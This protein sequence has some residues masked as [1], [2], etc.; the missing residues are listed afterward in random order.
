MFRFNFDLLKIKKKIV[1]FIIKR[2]IGKY[3]INTIDLESI[4]LNDNG[5]AIKELEIDPSLFEMF[6]NIVKLDTNIITDLEVFIPWSSI[7]SQSSKLTINKITLIFDWN[8]KEKI[9]ITE[10]TQTILQKTFDIKAMETYIEQSICEDKDFLLNSKSTENL[11]TQDA[12]DKSISECDGIHSLTTIIKSFVDNIQVFFDLIDIKVNF[13]DDICLN[14]QLYGVSIIQTPINDDTIE[15]S[16]MTYDIEKTIKIDEITLLI[17]DRTLLSLMSPR[18][19][20]WSKMSDDNQISGQNFDEYGVNVSVDF[21]YIY[22][23]QSIVENII[24]IINT[25]TPCF[26]S[27]GGNNMIKDHSISMNVTINKWK[28]V[29]ELDEENQIYSVSNDIYFKYDDRPI[30]GNN[31]TS[32]GNEMPST[33]LKSKDINCFPLEGSMTPKGESIM[34]S[35]KS[36]VSHQLVTYNLGV[37]SWE[38]Y[39]K[40]SSDNYD[41]IRSLNKE[42]YFL[43]LAFDGGLFDKIKIKLAPILFTLDLTFITKYLSIIQLLSSIGTTKKQVKSNSI[44]KKKNIVNLFCDLVHIIIKIPISDRV[45]QQTN[46]YDN[47]YYEESLFIDIHSLLGEFNNKNITLTCQKLLGNLLAHDNIINFLSIKVP[48]KEKPI[49]LQIM[50]NNL[51]DQDRVDES[52]DWFDN[53]RMVIGHQEVEINRNIKNVDLL[54]RDVMR[55]SKQ[56]LKL[57]LRHCNLYLDHKHFQV[58][59]N[60]LSEF[61]AW[62]SPFPTVESFYLLI[63]CSLESLSVN[64]T[65]HNFRYTILADMINILNTVNFY[66]RHK[67]T[68][69][70]IRD[71]YLY[72]NNTKKIILKKIDDTEPHFLK[73]GIDQLQP[74]SLTK[75]IIISMEFS[76]IKMLTR[77][78]QFSRLEKDHSFWLF[79]VINFFKKEY[80]IEPVIDTRTKL[81]INAKRLLTEYR[82]W[83]IP[84]KIVFDINNII[85]LNTYMGHNCLYSVSADYFD[86]G[87]STKDKMFEI[88]KNKDI[89]VIWMD[90]QIEMVNGECLFE[91]CADT[92]RII[93][94]IVQEFKKRNEKLELIEEDDEEELENEIGTCGTQHFKDIEAMVND[95]IRP[96]SIDDENMNKSI[97]AFSIYKLRNKSISAD[98]DKLNSILHSPLLDSENTTIIA[99]DINIEIRL[100]N[101]FEVDN[102]KDYNCYMMIIFDKINAIWFSTEDATYKKLFLTI[103][104]LESKLIYNKTKVILNPDIAYTF[105]SWALVEDSD[106]ALLNN[107]YHLNAMPKQ[108]ACQFL[109]WSNHISLVLLFDDE[110]QEDR[111]IIDT[112]PIILN[113]NQKTIDFIANYINYDGKLNKYYQLETDYVEVEDFNKFNKKS[114]S[115][116]HSVVIDI[117]SIKIIINYKSSVFDL[118]WNNSATI[119]NFVNLDGTK[120]VLKPF[121]YMGFMDTDMIIYEMSEYYINQ[122]KMNNSLNIIKSLSP[123]RTVV[124]IGSGIVNLVVI[125]TKVIGSSKWKYGLQKGVDKF[126]SSTLSEF[127]N[128]AYKIMNTADKL[129]YGTET[130]TLTLPQDEYNADGIANAISK[131]TKDTIKGGKKTM[132]DLK[133]NLSG[134]NKKEEDK[135]K[136]KELEESYEY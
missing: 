69:F 77:H 72:N 52:T 104:H 1:L 48:K 17:N 37:K 7:L 41:L 59:D 110:A 35:M 42:D 108:K 135:N 130:L 84:S 89:N 4:Q 111:F 107:I 91:L 109:D 14:L 88:V 76:N 103:R 127:A 129:F 63:N 49:V 121:R 68:Y 62:E 86:I 51:F 119:L 83:N 70:Q 32:I 92:I 50:N 53:D 98:Y 126:K 125:P 39:E 114:V 106:M 96:I 26:V 105:K 87:L 8:F 115:K 124:R 93:N 6:D 102:S 118:S 54:N 117:N 67:Y 36:T 21:I 22:T 71:L 13:S 101:G 128:I 112:Q 122:I 5:F 85:F 136:F 95:A 2:L 113:L 40:S 18:V 3:V 99:K 30:L 45:K 123:I 19:D 27:G 100:Y 61:A 38:I 58:I 78:E 31:N 55:K 131:F 73:V 46:T 132:L 9:D 15:E 11:E 79:D 12:S 80:H 24:P 29:Y 74:S 23:C 56:I 133:D 43:K 65:H 20:I 75:D 97:A 81:Y 47:K 94:G 82:I 57:N 90:K 116:Q 44:F 134:K 60:L 16:L 34:S 28:F 64:M 120:L 25:I 10:L 66:T 33:Y